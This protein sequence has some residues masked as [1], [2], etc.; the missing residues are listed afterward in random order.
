MRFFTWL[1]PVRHAPKSLTMAPL[2][3]LQGHWAMR[4]DPT[5]RGRSFG[6]TEATAAVTR[7]TPKRV[8]MVGHGN[9]VWTGDIQEF[10]VL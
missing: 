1:C 8:A 6:G 9:E 4:Q 5:L 7:G 3:A 10:R 2:G